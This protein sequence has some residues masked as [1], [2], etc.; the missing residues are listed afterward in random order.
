MIRITG[1]EHRGRKLHVPRAG[2]RP[3]KDMVR[4]ALYSALGASIAD[5][6]LADLFAGSGAFGLE[7]LSRGAAEAYWVE[8]DDRT[9]EVLRSN[10]AAIFPDQAEH[11]VRADVFLWLKAASSPVGLDFVVADP[12]Y[13]PEGE[14]SWGDLLLAALAG[15]SVLK[16]EGLF[17]LEQHIDQPVIDNPS[18]D[19]IKTARYGETH[20][21]YYRKKAA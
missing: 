4:Q 9:H 5:K 20:L 6:R 12:P 15:S 8:S 16:P 3:T 14:A 2:V 7:A 21:V 17:V 19:M 10:V 18:F 11:A 1:G 13:R